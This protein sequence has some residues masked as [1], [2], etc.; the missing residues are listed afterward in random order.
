MTPGSRGDHSKDI[1]SRWI[2]GS[3]AGSILRL[4][5]VTGFTGWTTSESGLT[6]P[7]RRPDGLIHVT[8]ADDLEPVPY[9][10]EIETYASSDADRQVYEDL[11]LAT[12]DKRVVPE[13][14][15]LVLRPK[16]NAQVRG[17]YSVVSRSGTSRVSAN[18]RVINLWDLEASALL[19]TGDAGL[20]P[21]VPLTQITGPAEIT[22]QECRDRIER[23]I[24]PERRVNYCA[25]TEILGRLIHPFD[26][27]ERIF[28]RGTE[29]IES[30]LFQDL[31]CQ[32]N[33]RAIRRAMEFRFGPMPEDLLRTLKTMF[34]PAPLEAI[35]NR[36]YQCSNYDDFRALLTAPPTE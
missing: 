9:L 36:L 12:I 11:L 27:L 13:A 35:L 8:F 21:W 17:E 28:S 24:P 32:A 29:M 6:T 30:P 20:I 1:V 5:G 26:L 18:W 34:E 4:S 31:E 2:L 3:Q 15:C 33:Q 14:I 22:L 10:I 7:Q 25:A 23:D 16:G 19:A